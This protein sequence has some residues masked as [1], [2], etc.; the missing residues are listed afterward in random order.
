M[1]DV[2]KSIEKFQSGLSLKMEVKRGTGTRDQDKVVGK[3]RGK[4]MEEIEE[5]AEDL[6]NQIRERAENLR[7]VGGEE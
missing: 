4:D 5:Y 2:D 6:E 1:N 7:S 3:V